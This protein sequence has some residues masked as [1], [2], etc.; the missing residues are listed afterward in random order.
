VRFL[1]SLLLPF[2]VAPAALAQS[3][4]FQPGDSLGLASLLGAGPVTRTVAG[5]FDGDLHTDVLLL[6]GG[7]LRLIYG[8]PTYLAGWGSGLLG[9]DLALVSGA[10]V[11]G[12]DAVVLLDASGPALVSYTPGAAEDFT[13]DDLQLTGWGGAQR[14][15][16]S[17][18]GDRVLYGLGAGG[19]SL[20]VAEG[21]FG[22]TLA[23]RS[24]PLDDPGLELLPCDWTGTSD[25]EVLVLT[26][27]GVVVYDRQGVKLLEMFA[28][29]DDAFAVV[30]RQ[31]GYAK[32]RVASVVSQ[33]GSTDQFLHVMDE[34]TA[35]MPISLGG[36]QAHTMVA[37]DTDGD[38]DD[39]LVI[40]HRLVLSPPDTAPFLFTN[41][42][43]G[44]PP[45]TDATF[46][47]LPGDTF[48]MPL[49]VGTNAGPDQQSTPVLTDL[50]RDGDLDLFYCVQE[51]R[52]AQVVHNDLFDHTEHQI[53]PRG[54]VVEMFSSPVL[55]I[56]TLDLVLPDAMLPDATHMRVMQRDAWLEQ[57]GSTTITDP[58]LARP[59]LSPQ[60][61]ATQHLELPA[62]W[63]ELVVDLFGFNS[64]DLRSIELALV[65]IVDDEVVAIGPA[66]LTMNSLFPATTISLDGA[67]DGELD[68]DLAPLFVTLDGLFF[69]GGPEGGG[70]SGP[71]VDP[72]P[73]VDGGDAPEPPPDIE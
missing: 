5:D 53:T 10:G 68:G 20:L 17:G 14:V 31:D 71:S 33:P 46:T 15:A 13:V 3:A 55:S 39:D 22:G 29:M 6:D 64:L 21:A 67:L 60:G 1:L 37:G 35:E 63:G 42:S 19:M 18:D 58:E 27:G 36:S 62:T 65:Q 25:D 26:E 45:G 23:E 12:H 41:R 54:G 24:L 38:G 11:T 30:L 32:D 47:A 73:R 43:D 9:Y 4:P 57:N 51:S 44:D 28:P 48:L 34:L 49:G 70:G 40:T 72:P 69:V 2:L 16:V 56:M 8:P 59:I 7:E 61:V 52:V 66:T 50:S